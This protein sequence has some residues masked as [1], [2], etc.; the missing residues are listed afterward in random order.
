MDYSVVGKAIDVIFEMAANHLE[1]VLKVVLVAPVTKKGEAVVQAAKPVK[2]R[3][4]RK[5]VVKA[6]PTKKVKAKA[7]GPVTP[8]AKAEA[9]RAAKGKVKPPVQQV[10]AEPQPIRRGGLPAPPSAPP[11]SP[12][13]SLTPSQSS[14]LS[15]LRDCG[16]SFVSGEEI[17][18]RA[19][20]AVLSV[21]GLVKKLRGVGY[22]VEGQRGGKTPGYRL[23]ENG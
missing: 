19:G 9:K 14:V 15:V 4:G 23:V 2:S 3:P 8:I 10:A 5:P 16:A 22:N 12:N 6:K 1:R 21:G 20:V 13:G 7:K 18:S 11:A 17:A